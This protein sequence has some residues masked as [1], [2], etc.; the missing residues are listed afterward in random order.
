MSIGSLMPITGGDVVV[1]SVVS[2]GG[3][4]TVDGRWIRFRV[5][6]DL[7]LGST[8]AFITVDFTFH[9]YNNCCVPHSVL[10]SVYKKKRIQM[11]HIHFR[12]DKS[13]TIFFI[14]NSQLQMMHPQP[15]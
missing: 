9:N 10:L 6:W 15:S 1:G 2:A 8:L 3:R 11:V 7:G 13:R 5:T 14:Q 4:W 12:F